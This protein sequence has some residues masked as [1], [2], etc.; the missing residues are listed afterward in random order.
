MAAIRGWL[1]DV[2]DTVLSVDFVAMVHELA[3]AASVPPAV[4]T[5]PD[6]ELNAAVGRGTLGLADV[7]ADVLTAAGQ[8]AEPER[9]A[10]LVRRDRELLIEHSRVHADAVSFLERLRSAG[11][12]TAIVSNCAD[13]T[14]QLLEHHGLDALVDHLVLSC[15]VGVVKPDPAIFTLALGR[16]DLPA[17]EVAF[18]DD[19]TAFCQGAQDVGIRPVQIIRRGDGPDTAPD[20]AAGAAPWPRVDSCHR[21]EPHTL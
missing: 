15:E 14:R 16:L 11:V 7:F 18:L 1:I 5:D 6:D 10:H 9:I 13:N 21:L 3:E 19:Q 20:G 4:F 17:G 12:P 8:R 2:Y